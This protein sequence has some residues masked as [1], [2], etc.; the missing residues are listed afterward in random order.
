MKNILIIL[1]ALLISS[2][3]TS[4]EPN[5]A[6]PETNEPVVSSSSQAV[7]QTT[8]P[9]VTTPVVSSQQL[10]SSS[11]AQ[12]VYYSEPQP[13]VTGKRPVRSC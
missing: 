11:S 7:S 13:I 10:P 5:N 9:E 4:P 6:T 3:L 1:S 8:Q 12:T 2:C